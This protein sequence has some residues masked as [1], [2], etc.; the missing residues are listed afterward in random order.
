MTTSN[1]TVDTTENRKVLCVVYVQQ[2][3][4]CVIKQKVNSAGVD[5]S[6]KHFHAC[7][8]SGECVCEYVCVCDFPPPGVWVLMKSHRTCVTGSSS[9]SCVF[10]TVAALSAPSSLRAIFSS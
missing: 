4:L 5:M 6:V 8:I 10:K 3:D 2:W 1:A 9:A 7:V